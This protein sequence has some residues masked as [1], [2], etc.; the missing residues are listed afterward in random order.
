MTHGISA[1]LLR[2]PGERE[3]VVLRVYEADHHDVQL[4]LSHKVAC[5]FADALKRLLRE[6]R[7]SAVPE[8]GTTVIGSVLLPMGTRLEF[9]MVPD[10]S[11]A[12]AALSVTITP[13]PTAVITF[14]GGTPEGDPP[15]SFTG[16]LS[17]P[18]D[19]SLFIGELSRCARLAK[20]RSGK[21]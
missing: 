4:A 1:T 18:G 11:D 5:E 2:K 10:P 21:G 15:E 17:T 9:T 20:L 3:V 19:R 12:E 13:P 16:T 8:D 14:D 6:A 7:H